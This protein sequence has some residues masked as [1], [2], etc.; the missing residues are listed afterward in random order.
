[1]AQAHTHS[2]AVEIVSTFWSYA[3]KHGSAFRQ[4]SSCP[5]GS[6][7]WSFTSGVHKAPDCS[8]QCSQIHVE[9]LPYDVQIGLRSP[10]TQTVKD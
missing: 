5:L 10:H 4:S 8:A 3:A 9:C 7:A 2:N 6:E 1:M